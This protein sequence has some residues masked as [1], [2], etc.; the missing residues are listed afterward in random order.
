MKSII[1]K[2][3]ELANID[4]LAVVVR[5]LKKQPSSEWTPFLYGEV[6]KMVDGEFAQPLE[7]IGWGPCNESGSEAYIS[8]FFP[9]ETV[10][11]KESIYYEKWLGI[12]LSKLQPFIYASDTTSDMSEDYCIC[13]ARSMPQWASRLT[14]KFNAVEAKQAKNMAESE[15]LA[16]GI[17]MESPYASLCIDI[18]SAP[19]ENNLVG[20]SAIKSVFCKTYKCNPD[21]WL[22]LWKVEVKRVN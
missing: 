2:P 19:H 6:H 13:C 16:C 5:P 20:G 4:R 21:T 1:L 8:P 15:M 12:P 17:N 14:I 3:H 9:G 18:E 7:I 22:W 11:V 10:F